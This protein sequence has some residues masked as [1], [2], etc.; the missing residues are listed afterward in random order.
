MSSAQCQASEVAQPVSQK[1]DSGEFTLKVPSCG[2]QFGLFILQ[3]SND[4][5]WKGALI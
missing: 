5:Y 4:C 3:V 2:Y 1:L